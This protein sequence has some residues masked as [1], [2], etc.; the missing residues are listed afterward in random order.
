MK[1]R[2]GIV[3]AAL[4]VCGAATAAEWPPSGDVEWAWE[5]A[6]DVMPGDGDPRWSGDANAGTSAEVTP[7]KT[8]LDA[9]RQAGVYVNSLCGGDG[10][11]G[12]CR[13]LLRDGQIE[14]APHSLLTREEVQRSYVLACKSCPRSDLV[15]EVP[16]ESQ[17]E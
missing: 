9:A 15:V 4:V 6:G 16:I 3:F 7:D 2:Y 8:L 12:R 11:C 10:I 1:I 17:L 13:V 5:Y 14:E